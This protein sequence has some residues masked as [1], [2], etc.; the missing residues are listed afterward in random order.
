[1]AMAKMAD[2]SA[3]EPFGHRS[4]G[5]PLRAGQ[6]HP[7]PRRQSLRRGR[8]ARPLLQCPAFVVSQHDR[9]VV[10]LSRHGVQR[11][12]ATAEVQDFF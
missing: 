9:L 8:A 3:A 10:A 2:E 7:R 11:T 1:M 4:I 5:E 6:Y 12:R